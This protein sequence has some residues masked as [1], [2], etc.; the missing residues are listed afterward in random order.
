MPS[1]F[2]PSV[3]KRDPQRSLRARP[4]PKSTQILPNNC[5]KGCSGSRNT[6][7]SWPNVGLCRPSLVKCWPRSTKLID[8]GQGRNLANVGQ[9]RSLLVEVLPKLGP[10]RMAE[11]WPK[12]GRELNFRPHSPKF[13]RCW[14]QLG[15]VGPTLTKSWPMPAKIGH[16]RPKFGR[17]GFKLAD[18]GQKLAGVGQK[19]AKFGQDWSMLVKLWPRLAKFGQNLRRGLSNGGPNVGQACPRSA[20]RGRGLVKVCKKW[21]MLVEGGST[22]W[23]KS[24]TEFAKV[25]PTS[26]KLGSKLGRSSAP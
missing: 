1:T 20:K 5:R 2:P 16:L 13:G 25:W 24:A 26:A 15:Q 8:V 14:S 11:F 23:P 10:E 4:S 22:R 9:T 7:R 3:A 6:A 21:P 18:V 17:C 12:L 19:L